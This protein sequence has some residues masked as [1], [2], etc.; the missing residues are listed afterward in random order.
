M[1]LKQHPESMRPVFFVDET[2]E[3]RQG[4]K[5]K[6]KG[7][8]RDAVRSSHAQVVKT[9]G[10]KWLVF[11]L[12]MR[13]PFVTRAFALPFLSILQPSI[14]CD[15][16]KGRRHKTTLDWTCQ[17][18]K[19]IIRWI[20]HSSFIVV[21]DGGFA[22]GRLALLCLKY[23]V[24]L[25]TR[26]KMNSRLFAFPDTPKVGQAGR[27]A[28][29]GARLA[30]FKQMLT[31]ENLGWKT[32]EITSYGGKKKCVQHITGITLWDVDGYGPIPIRWVLVTD[33]EGKLAPL[34]LMCTDSTMS[35]ERI[36]ELYIERWNQEVTFEEVR[37]HLG[38]ETQRQWSDKAIA[39]T[40]PILM[41]LYSMVCLIA[42]EIHKVETIKME[43]AAW[44]EKEVPAFSDLLKTVRKCL[45][46]DSSF[47]RKTVLSTSVEKKSADSEQWMNFIVECLSKA[48]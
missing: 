8:Y 43:H 31:I 10:L 48:S 24:T 46:K 5:I 39:R 30:S 45:W 3:R 6:A 44:Y 28:K 2:L 27:K 36:I 4:K 33:P 42:N 7:Y 29:K 20:G 32:S 11:M 21:G 22:S 35:V 1:L 23:Q 41:G 12:S 14:K 34:P 17:A 40:T 25:V 38:V 16:A 13:F 47:L 37:E 15:K 18:V 19:Q 9:N 26:L